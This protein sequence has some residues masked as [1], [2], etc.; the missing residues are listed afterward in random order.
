MTA[1]LPQGQ[2]TVRE[3]QSSAAS[4]MRL[5]SVLQQAQVERISTNELMAFS[6]LLMKACKGH[7]EPIDSFNG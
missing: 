2:L 3:I 5:A 4:I 6:T 7:N 1:T